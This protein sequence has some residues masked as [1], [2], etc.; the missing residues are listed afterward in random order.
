MRDFIKQIK[1]EKIRH[2]REFQID[3]SD[4]EMK[5]LI[6]TGKN[7]SG[8]T[9][10][11]ERIRDYLKVIPDGN[12]MNLVSVWPKNL[13]INQQW[14]KELLGIS[15]RSLEQQSNMK[16]YNDNI[17][18]FEDSIKRYAKGLKIVLTKEDSILEKYRKGEYIFAYFNATRNVRIDIPTNVPKI[19]LQEQY[20]MQNNIGNM[21]LYRKQL[22][23]MAMDN[24]LNKIR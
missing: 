12:L 2:L 11:L 22:E 24:I 10:L 21:F 18:V 4:T 23:E 3:I 14:Y 6:L 1:I 7:G 17:K 8:K 5:H 16:Q 20:D 9:T 15:N 13:K 19:Q